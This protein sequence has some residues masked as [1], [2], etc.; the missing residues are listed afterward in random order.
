S[1]EATNFGKLIADHAGVKTVTFDIEKVTKEFETY[2]FDYHLKTQPLHPIEAILNKITTPLKDEASTKE[3][4]RFHAKL[5]AK[6]RIR[7]L[8]VFRFAEENNLLSVGAAHLT[9]DLPGLFCKFGVDDIADG[10]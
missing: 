9:E 2:D 4:R 7:A 3:I 8:F 10:K 5:Y 6:H 1:E